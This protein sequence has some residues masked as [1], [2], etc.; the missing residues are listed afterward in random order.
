MTN[1]TLFCLGYGFTAAAL[2]RRLKP[3]GWRIAGTTRSAQKAETMRAAGVEPRLWGDGG[4]D[5]DWIAEAG[6]LLVSTPPDDEGCP[7]FRAAHDAVAAGRERLTWIGYL[8]TNGVYGD[9]QGAWVDEDSDLFPTTARARRR[10]RAE[11]DW[12]GFGRRMEPAGRHLPPT[13]HLRPRPF[14]PRHGAQGQG[15]ARLQGRAGLQPHACGRHR[16]G[17]GRE[18]GAPRRPRSLQ[19]RRR[20]AGAAAGTSSNTPAA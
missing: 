19:P 14:G 10:I 4:F 13:R 9:H 11:A 20:R 2:A 16:H 7:A 6:A 5:P 3:E 18:H 8:S 17:A 15:A 12:A 1:K